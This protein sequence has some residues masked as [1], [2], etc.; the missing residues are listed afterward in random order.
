MGK[1]TTRERA[2][3]K[4][5]TIPIYNSVVW[6]VVATDLVRERK[7]M[8]REFGDYDGLDDFAAMCTHHH[9]DNKFALFFKPDFLSINVVSHEIFHLTLRMLEKVSSNINTDNH[10]HAAYL[11]G[12]LMQLIFDTIHNRKTK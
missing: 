4:R 10:E 2:F 11:H 9:T 3:K 8:S 1:K 12:Y 6:I 5:I 7:K